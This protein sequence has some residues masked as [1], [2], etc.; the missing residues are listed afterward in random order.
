V[1]PEGSAAGS[2]QAAPQGG[3]AR[4]PEPEPSEQSDLQA[5]MSIGNF[6]ALNPEQLIP[7]E[8][9]GLQGEMYVFN[10]TLA[11]YG[12]RRLLCYRVVGEQL[13]RRI[14]MCQLDENFV[15]IPGSASP[16]SDMI[17]FAVSALDE[18]NT[19]W[20]ADPRLFVLSR[21]LVVTW[22]DG[23]AKPL[24]NQFLIEVD[25]DTLRPIGRARRLTETRAQTN[26]EKNWMLFE[27][28]GDLFCLYSIEP[29]RVLKLAEWGEKEVIFTDCCDVPWDDSKYKHTY[30]ELRGGAQPFRVGDVFYNFCHSSYR[31]KSKRH[32]VA[33]LYTFEAKGPFRPV[34]LL[35]EPIPLPNPQ[36]ADTLRPKLNA[37]AAAVVYPCG[38]VLDGDR[39][40]IT[41]GLNDDSSAIVDVMQSE[42]ESR[43][44]PV[45]WLENRPS[46]GAASRVPD[47]ETA[48]KGEESLAN[49]PQ[50]I[51][52]FYWVAKGFSKGG[53]EAS[54][55]RF[56][57]GNFGD[58]AS[59]EIAE[60]LGGRSV[61]FADDKTRERRMLSIG[62]ILHRARNG[63]AVWGSG[64]KGS[65]AT[66]GEGVDRFD[67]YALRGPISYDFLRRR[68]IDVSRVSALFDPAVLVAELR[69]DWINEQ[70]ASITERKPFGIVPHFREE[71]L[72]RKIY[73]EHADAIITPDGSLEIVIPKLLACDL[74]LSSSLH[75]IIVSEALG[76]PAIWL[77]PKA[78]ED[79]LKYYDYYLGTSRHKIL[80]AESIDD[81]LKA[82]PMPLPVFDFQAML[83]TFPSDFIGRL[84]P[85]M[86]VGE[87]VQFGA[88]SQANTL[89][90]VALTGFYPP[91]GWGTWTEAAGASLTTYAPDAKPGA[92]RVRIALKPFNPERLPEPQ[93]IRISV[94]GDVA[95]DHRW[96]VGDGELRNFD[97][98]IEALGPD[99]MLH[100]EIA[101]GVGVPM[102]KLG[103]KD[104]ERVLGAGLVHFGLV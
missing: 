8:W 65:N 28:E 11:C 74:I 4:T 97:L 84:N 80:C 47:A 100:V 3:A 54:G 40:I 87:R 60:L 36:G 18:R 93:S 22:N 39:W 92:S 57:H 50:P 20:H 82:E 43:L 34:K 32:Y 66:L 98:P 103:F 24:N 91:Q 42:I 89:S 23:L 10:P 77:R 71:A 35:E 26:H 7:E 95:L 64:L 9:R 99:G 30:G 33:A 6:T 76:I 56:E 86:H 19:S 48:R 96:E 83:A 29:H 37:A 52:L 67:V 5:A 15:P 75:G 63:D 55:E 62:S 31:V 14:A 58:V 90:R 17:E 102:S 13:G 85:T 45:R 81:A 94:N 53:P 1:T 41:Y 70:R 88:N 12:G 51:P 68:N 46:E 101:A 61:Y 49:H 73:H 44:R 104:D 2:A 16:F 72:Y 69:R 21:G 79:P 27:S 25:A 78:G 38:A 59:K